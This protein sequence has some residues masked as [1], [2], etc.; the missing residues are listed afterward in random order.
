MGL[1]RA[2][3][4][5]QPNSSFIAGVNFASAG[6]G[7]LNETNFGTVSVSLIL[8][9][10]LFPDDTSL[11]LHFCL[12]TINALVVMAEQPTY[13]YYLVAWDV[14][15]QVVSMSEQ[16]DQ[17]KTV[18]I[19]LQNQLSAWGALKLISKSMFLIVSGSND[20]VEYLSNP[21]VQAQ[22]NAAQFLSLVVGAYRTTLT[23]STYKSRAESLT[24]CCSTI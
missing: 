15:M 20:I 17:F 12:M 3:P 18:R 23:V 13:L 10:S 22:G 9:P 5:L 11:K 14:P 2:P 6:S 1:P 7:L 21:D 19:L 16:M 4:Y 24:Y 8:S